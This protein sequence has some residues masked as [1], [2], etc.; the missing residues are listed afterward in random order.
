M[1]KWKCTICGY[2]HA[3][4]APPEVCPVC[5]AD[6]SKFIE[7]TDTTEAE[8]KNNISQV[9]ADMSDSKKKDN[10]IFN[11]ASKHHLHPIS[12]HFPNG[13]IPIIV[14]LIF[15]ALI[16]KS[17]RI[18]AA[19]CYN[20]IFVAL[21]M[22]LVLFSGYIDWKKKYQGSLTNYFKIKIACASI[23]IVT[24][25]LSIVW[26][27]YFPALIYSSAISRWGYLLL[28]FIMLGAA[29]VAGFIGGK[30]VFKD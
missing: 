14:A 2:I 26:H 27:L 20:L 5:K 28:N 24:L 23:V 15:L 10:I 3:G 6:K 22:P 9:S 16:I 25:V 8:T 18:F 13:I 12:V 30:L 1:K 21:T 7:I 11:L 19:A 4:E 17:E 29:G